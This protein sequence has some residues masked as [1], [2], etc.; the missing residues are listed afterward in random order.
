[1][2]LDR[3]LELGKGYDDRWTLKLHGFAAILGGLAM[4]GAVFFLIG[5]V[6]ALF[7]G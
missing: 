6:V 2:G 4:I 5:G 1:M 7:G 3:Y